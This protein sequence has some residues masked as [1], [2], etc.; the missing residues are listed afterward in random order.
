M[1]MPSAL[2]KALL[3]APLVVALVAFA[4]CGGA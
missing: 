3:A 4:S 1:P 2:Q